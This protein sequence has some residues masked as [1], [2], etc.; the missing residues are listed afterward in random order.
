MDKIRNG[1]D[2][3][4]IGIDT[5]RKERSLSYVRESRLLARLKPGGHLSV[6]FPP[7]P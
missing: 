6:Y 4:D 5:A 7:T 2:I 1:Y 3:V